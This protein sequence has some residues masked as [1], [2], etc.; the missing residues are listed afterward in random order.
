MFKHMQT[1]LAASAAA[2][3]TRIFGAGNI[4]RHIHQHSL[5]GYNHYAKAKGSIATANRHTGKPH[6]HKREIARN[7]RKAAR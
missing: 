6:E 7:V 1:L 5:K 2:T 3:S 4:E